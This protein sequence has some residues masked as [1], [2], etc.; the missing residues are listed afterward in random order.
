MKQNRSSALPKQIEF[1][2]FTL[3]SITMTASLSVNK[4][5][6]VRRACAELAQ[7]PTTSIRTVAHILGMLVATFPGAKYGPLHYKCLEGEKTQALCVCAG[8]YESIM[9]VKERGSLNQLKWWVENVSL[10]TTTY[11]LTSLKVEM[12]V[13]SDAGFT[14]WGG[15]AEVNG[16]TERSTAGQWLKEEK[17]INEKTLNTGTYSRAEG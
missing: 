10:K 9:T 12:L 14:G 13:I 8:N 2:G 4:R 3:D 5:Q 16:G 1:L 11:S 7:S 17:Q 6:N 15:T